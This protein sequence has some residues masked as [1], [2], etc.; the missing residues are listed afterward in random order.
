MG[1]STKRIYEYAYRLWVSTQTCV[2]CIR[3]H[4][5][6]DKASS[7]P[8]TLIVVLGGHTDKYM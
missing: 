4:D 5:W 6:I 1:F 2:N 8:Y 7:S 3:D